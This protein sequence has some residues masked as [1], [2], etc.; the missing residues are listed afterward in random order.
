MNLDILETD[1][2]LGWLFIHFRVHICDVSIS[3]TGRVRFVFVF[4]PKD[5][6]STNIESIFLLLLLK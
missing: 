5:G 6:R 2:G 3:G 1:Y 4:R